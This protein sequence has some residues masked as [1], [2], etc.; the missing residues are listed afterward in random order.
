MRHALFAVLVNQQQ[1][2]GKYKVNFT[3]REGL[4]GYQLLPKFLT[5]AQWKPT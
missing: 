1:T 5:F 3:G 4:S 2:L